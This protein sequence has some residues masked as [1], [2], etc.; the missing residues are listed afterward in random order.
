MAILYG[1]T[2]SLPRRGDLYR[3]DDL[4]AAIRYLAHKVAERVREVES[5]GWLVWGGCGAPC[6]HEE[7]L[8][9]R[10]RRSF[11]RDGRAQ[12]V[13]AIASGQE[14]W[15]EYATLLDQEAVYGA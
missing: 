9:E 12:I 15:E 2:Q 6:E 10:L 4:D 14:S 11:A 3:T 8:A 13:L 1:L 5:L 7:H